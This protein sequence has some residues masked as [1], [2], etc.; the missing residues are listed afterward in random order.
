MISWRVK[1]ELRFRDFVDHEARVATNPMFGSISEDTKTKMDRRDG[2]LQ[3]GSLTKRAGELSFAAL[4]GSGQ[5]VPTGIAPARGTIGKVSCLYC[6]AGHTLENCISLRN[7]PYMDRI[8]FL[9]SKGLCFGCLSSDHAAR[10]CPER[11]SCTFPNCAKKHPAVLHTSSVA[12]KQQSENPSAG[13]PSRE[14]VARV[15]NAMVNLDGKIKTANNDGLSRTG[16]AVVPV[17]VWIK[18]SKIPTVT[19]AFLDSSSSSTFCTETLMRQVGVNGPK[20]TISLTTLKRK[21]VL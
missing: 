3:K 18:G 17:K 16:M 8:E 6:N 5:N 12:R 21:T 19:Y 14:G 20:T 11:K 7:R 9:K 4:V 1:Q 15:Q 13:P 10:N 2:R